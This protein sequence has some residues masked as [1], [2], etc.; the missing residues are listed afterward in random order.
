MSLLFLEWCLSYD[1]PNRIESFWISKITESPLAKVFHSHRLT[2]HLIVR[3]DIAF[4]NATLKTT[5]ERS[6]SFQGQTQHAM[7]L[8]Q[9]FSTAARPFRCQKYWVSLIFMM[10]K[11]S[12]SKKVHMNILSM[13]YSY[14]Y[15]KKP[16]LLEQHA[17]IILAVCHQ[18]H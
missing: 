17:E 3:S 5:L 6:C 14:R 4:N 2:V 18:Q 13:C 12:Q 9:L 16:L 10:T 11:P 8:K 15:P 1:A 7:P